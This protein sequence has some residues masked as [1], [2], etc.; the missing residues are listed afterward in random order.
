M[1]RREI[2]PPRDARGR[3]GCKLDMENADQI[4]IDKVLE[5]NALPHPGEIKRFSSGQ[6]NRVYAIGN[7]FVIKIESDLDWARGNFRHQ[8]EITK[9]LKEAGVPVPT[10]IDF[11]SGEGTHYL[12]T[13][14]L[15]GSNLVDKWS[16]LSVGQR[17]DFIAQA[18]GYLQKIHTIRSNAYRLPIYS[19]DDSGTLVQAMAA[20]IDFSRLDRTKLT[21]EQRENV[22]LLEQFYKDHN[23]LLDEQGTAVLVHNDFHFENILADGDK[24]TGIID[25][26][27]ASYAPADYELRSMLDYAH[28]PKYY[29]EEHLEPYFEGKQLIDEMQLYKKYYPELF[30][31]PN[32][33][34]RIKLYMIEDILD[35]IAGIQSG[36]WNAHAWERINKKID[37]VYSKNWLKN[38]L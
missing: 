33:E 6:I 12:L 26:D 16:T 24:V 31:H 4:L 11:N 5:K 37:D 15:P 28:A 20:R 34:N 17:E 3:D 19:Q 36:R 7:H 18:A 35:A 10:V 2:S 23:R 22:E 21:P 9:S 38:V 29:V 32:L 14:R 27:W 13:E 30:S 25:W 8:A 1:L